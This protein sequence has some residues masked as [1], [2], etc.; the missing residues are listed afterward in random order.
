MQ[1]NVKYLSTKFIKLHRPDAITCIFKIVAKNAMYLISI[2]WHTSA[3]QA[4]NWSCFKRLSRKKNQW[5]FTLKCWI[6]HECGF[7]LIERVLIQKLLDTDCIS[8]CKS[9]SE[10]GKVWL[11]YVHWKGFVCGLRISDSSIW[12]CLSLLKP[13]PCK[14]RNTRRMKRKIK[15][16]K[17]R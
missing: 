9:H 11:D 5:N 8:V 12:I 3:K 6:S 16:F 15:Y 4:I 2:K 7:I 17:S 13:N 10:E 1:T 14:R